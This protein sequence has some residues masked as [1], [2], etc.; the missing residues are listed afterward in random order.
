MALAKQ[1]S[2]LPRLFCSVCVCVTYLSVQRESP[3]VEMRLVQRPVDSA[4]GY[5]IKSTFLLDGW[6]GGSVGGGWRV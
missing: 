6:V 4:C 1:A 3:S 5:V 2:S